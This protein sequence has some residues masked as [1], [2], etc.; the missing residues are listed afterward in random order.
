MKLVERHIVKQNNIEWKTIDHLCFL[1]KNLYNYSVYLIRKQFELDGK[2][3]NY[4]SLEKEL[5]TTKNENY[6]NLPNNS[7]QQILM[8]LEKN[9]ISF[10]QA[11][12]SWK[13]DKTKFQGCPKPPNFKHKTKGRNLVIF[14]YQQVHI[15]ENGFIKFPKKTGLKP[16]KTKIVNNKLK[17]IR[18]IPQSSCYVIE[19]VYEKEITKNENLNKD[20]FLSIDLG[21]NNLASLTSNQPGFKPFLINGR[22]VKSINQYYNKKKSKIQSQL[23]KN[24]NK[25][26][27]ERLDKLQLKRNC[28]IDY[29]LHHVSKLIVNTCISNN[30]ANI[31]IGKNDGWKQEAELGKRNNQNFVNIPFDKLIHQIQYKAELVGINVILNEESY[32]SKCSALDLESIQKHSEYSGKRIKRGLFKYSKGLINSDINGSLNILRKVIGDDF[33][34]DLSNIGFVHNPAK[35]NPLRNNQ[36]KISVII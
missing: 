5:R 19:V 22:I 12:R 23:K 20:L 27:S 16:L 6:V 3:L 34:K 15:N 33:I 9:Y 1:S 32:T 4:N 24:H 17:Q 10:F 36:L 8:V 7:S 13:R 14:S 29:Y 31:L 21:V 25:N 11:L 18:I 30:L 26:W 35:V 28:K 2:F